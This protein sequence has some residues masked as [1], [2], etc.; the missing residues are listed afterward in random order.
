MAPAAPLLVSTGTIRLKKRHFS[1]GHGRLGRERH[2]RDHLIDGKT[3]C[4]PRASMQ[5]SFHS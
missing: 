3:I 2:P 1:K 4:A 5:N